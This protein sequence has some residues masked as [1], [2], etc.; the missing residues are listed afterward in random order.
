MVDINS[1]NP[2]DILYT[3]FDS[4]DHETEVNE[5]RISICVRQVVP[6]HE[7]PIR[8]HGGCSYKPENLTNIKPPDGE[9]KTYGEMWL[10]YVNKTK[11][12]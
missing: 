7:Y 8:A 6:N 1:I 2:N 5:G 3:T 12:Q 4:Y 11:D 9:Y 10:V